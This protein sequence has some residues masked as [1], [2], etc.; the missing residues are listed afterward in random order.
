MTIPPSEHMTLTD[1]ALLEAL[2]TLRRQ[3]AATN[4]AARWGHNGDDPALDNLARYLELRHHDI[5]PL[6][7]ELM[8]RGLSSLGRLESRVVETLDATIA[9]LAATLRRELA[10]SRPDEEQFFAGE[11]RLLEAANLL[12]GPAR[13]H[14]QTRIM[15]T[16][17]SE[18]ATDLA[19]V[20]AYAAAG[21]D[22]ARINC[23]HGSPET[24][25]AMAANVAAAGHALSS[26]VKLLMDIAGPKIRTEAVLPVK[27]ARLEVG[28]LLRLLARGAPRIDA[29]VRFSAT[30]SLPEI[31][32]R[33]SIG[34][35]VHYDDGK[36]EM[37]VESIAAGEAV[38]RVVRA[39]AGGVKLKSEKGLNLP[40]TELGLSPLTSKD[41]TDVATVIECAD[42]I[43]YSFVSRTEDLEILETALAQHGGK[44][45]LGIVAKIE[46]PE[47]VRNLPALI[48]RAAG[49]RPF[50]VM[51]A[52]GDLAAEIGFERLAE[53]QE[54]LL[55]LCEAASVPVIWATQV[56]ENMV[57]DGIPTRGEMTDAAMSVRAECVMLNK[58]PALPAAIEL[59]DRL[60]DRMDDH[61]SKKTPTLRALKSW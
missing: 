4:A 44:P 60:L 57:A 6:Q 10:I 48:E 25:R 16:L 24:W 59:L 7:R 18:A 33:L 43:G 31:V 46:L 42:L 45:G 15:V 54:E 5:R 34:H 19:L 55:W 1:E 22:I 36:L 13:S 58:G 61:M 52:R 21:M 28:S 27:G 14:R 41:Q 12:F 39:K 35:R 8:R 23:A 20:K 2:L 38:L 40:D 26:P 37:V 56:L 32:E 47:A 49:R 53:I 30:A 17:P 29:D 51:I 9:T 11:A 50:A 3:V